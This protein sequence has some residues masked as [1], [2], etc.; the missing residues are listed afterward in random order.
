MVVYVMVGGIFLA[1]QTMCDGCL[2]VN[3]DALL[4]LK[5]C[6]ECIKEKELNEKARGSLTVYNEYSSSPQTLVATTRF[7]SPEG[8]I[9]RI[10]KNIVV[11]GA[12]IE[13]GKII[14]STI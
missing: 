1:Y 5:H 11:P 14:A 6:K 3:M 13:E 8:K 4:K 12:K 7:E 10:E 9:F 2:Y